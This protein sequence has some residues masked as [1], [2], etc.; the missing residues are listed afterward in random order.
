MW[1]TWAQP[2]CGSQNCG[3]VIRV[4]TRIFLS[5][6]KI[7]FKWNCHKNERLLIFGKWAKL[8]IP[9]LYNP[10]TFWLQCTYWYKQYDIDI[11][12]HKHIR[13]ELLNTGFIQCCY[14]FSPFLE[15]TVSF[16][17][18]TFLE[19]TSFFILT[20]SLHFLFACVIHSWVST[21]HSKF[22]EELDMSAINQNTLKFQLTCDF[23]F[24]R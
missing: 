8:L 9:G 23:S 18:P 7:K 1:V 6:I 5:N 19:A 17:H 4:E 13:N 12:T 16:P 21:P 22:R 2:A 10:F 15:S 11:K 20:T 24:N 3:W 14:A